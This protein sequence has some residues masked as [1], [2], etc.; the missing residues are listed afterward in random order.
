LDMQGV[1]SPLFFLNGIGSILTRKGEGLIGFNYALRGPAKSPK[2]SVNP[3]SAFTPGMF[4]EIFRAPPPKLPE[5]EGAAPDTTPQTNAFGPTPQE[6]TDDAPV[7]DEA[8]KRAAQRKRDLNDNL[9]GGD[10]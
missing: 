6:A 1:I 5:V 7:V 9:S 2:V 10:R 3:L 4:R 8:A